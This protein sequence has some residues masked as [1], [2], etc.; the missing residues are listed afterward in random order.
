MRLFLFLFFLCISCSGF[1]QSPI[2][3]QVSLDDIQH[4]ELRISVEFPTLQ[5]KVLQVRMP[6]ASPGRYAVHNFAKNVYDV[7]AFNEKNEPLSIYRAEPNEW[8]V[9]GHNGY[10]R[11]EYTLF[12][13]HGD[14]TYS[15]VD[16]RKLHLN[17]PATFVRG[18]GMEKQPI[19]LTFDLTTRPD[20]KVAT[21]L[22]AVTT[23]ESR[24]VA[25]FSAPNY[26]YFY[27]SPTMVGDI[28]FRRWSSASNDKKYTIEIAM[29]HEGTEVE[30]DDYAAWTKQIVEEQKA[31][32]G[33]LPDFDY[34]RYT[35]LLTYNPY[36]FG[37]GMEHRNSTICSSKG[38]LE[39]NAKSLIGTVSHEF[40]HCWNVERIRPQSLEPFDFD[41]ANL[42]GELWFAEGFTSY[43]DDLVL[44]RTGIYSLED[45]AKGITGT[46]NY[47]I[48]NPGRA[49]RNPIEMSHQA[50]FVDAATAN[51]A[52][53]YGNTF[54]SY[55]PYGA[56]VGMVLDLQMRSTFKDKSLDDLM[57][58]MWE[59]YGKSEI[60]YTVATIEAALVEVT[61]DQAF[62]KSFFQKY[63]YDSEL[64][65]MTDLLKKFGLE[66][67]L[68][69]PEQADL[70]RLK[71]E[72]EEQKVT[73]AGNIKENHSFYAAGV[74]QGDRLLGI[75]KIEIQS[76]ENYKTAVAALQIGKSY[77]VRYVQNGV[78]EEGRFTVLV[79]PQFEVIVPEKKQRR[80]VLERQR[81]WL[82]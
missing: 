7:A 45:Y 80:E 26:Y 47:V 59:H 46:L 62:A 70:V 32:Y 57:Q 56:V 54:V 22:P 44:K 11:F 69:Y 66:M 40:F 53:N 30:L 20:W 55:Y 68:K 37:D 5:D 43:Y 10:V 8:Q 25:S 14:G 21:Q 3:Y 82:K 23:P 51:D 2:H 48:N 35:F 63:I 34:G 17:M 13:N 72:E 60:P 12:A 4:H 64:P 42:S 78:E 39:E 49:H 73:V 79:D 74:N 77:T 36:V 33:G 31:I 24:P 41:R 65:E 28:K 9:A 71:V 29:L 38:N 75:G 76:V 15:G 81:A 50:P 6:S 19:Q 1:T 27:D 58:Y 67:R 61:Q 18:I 16:N 52:N